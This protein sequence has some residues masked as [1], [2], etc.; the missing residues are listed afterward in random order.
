MYNW[1]TK[2]N[3]KQVMCVAVCESDPVTFVFCLFQILSQCFIIMCM[4]SLFVK[5]CKHKEDRV[6]IMILTTYIPN[7][8]F[9]LDWTVIVVPCTYVC[10]IK[11]SYYVYL[12]WSKCIIYSSELVF[13]YFTFF[14][15]LLFQVKDVKFVHK[16]T[17]EHLEVKTLV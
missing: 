7:S 11:L 1:E 16:Y 4:T 14:S 17:S 13:A 3:S 12:N 10:E 5:Y 8:N 2:P 6:L 15:S 9:Q